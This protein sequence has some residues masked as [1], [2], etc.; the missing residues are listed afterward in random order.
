MIIVTGGAGF[1]GSNIIKA[2]NDRGIT[3]IIVVDSFKNSTKHLNLNKLKVSDFIDKQDFLKH[4]PNFKNIQTIFHQGACSNTMET[5]GIYMMQ[6]NFEY[7]KELLNFSLANNIDFLYA[8]SASVY[9][10]GDTGFR[11]EAPCEYP[12]NIYAFSKLFFDN[13]V[14]QILQNKNL[15]SQVL[16]LRYFNVY[17]YNE[18][19][20]GT[21]ASVVYHMMNQIKDGQ[22]M[23]LFEG[24]ENFIRDFVF[25][26]DAVKVNLFCF[27]N[28][29]TGIYNCGTGKAESFVEIANTLQKE[30]KSA[31]IEYIPFPDKLKGKYQAYTQA[32]LTNLRQEGYTEPFHTLAQ[33]VSKYYKVFQKTGGYIV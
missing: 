32:D 30:N 27:D 9:G 31:Q 3:K 5:D 4:L 18:N 23:K 19:H 25:V 13:Y 11:E 22:P 8:S 20:K 29:T 15:S 33:G 10:N 26:E 17:G 1:I 16:G 2:L 6:N 28:K 12:L 7:S 21:M 14:R 24:S